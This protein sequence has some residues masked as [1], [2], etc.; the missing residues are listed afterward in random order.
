[1]LNSL[2]ISFKDTLIY[3]LGNIAVKIV[4]LV[5]IPLYTNPH[6]FSIDDFGIIGILEISGLVLTA[7]MASALPQSLTRWFWDTK[8]KG[9]QKGIFFM[10]FA[11]QLVV[12][13]LFCIVL[14]PLSGEFS[15]LIFSKSDLSGVLK[16]VILASSIQ[17]INNI[18]NTLM[19]LQSRSSLYTVT[20]LFKLILVLSLTI[21][22]I[23]VK[24]LGIEGIYLSQVIGNAVSILVLTKYIIRN[25]RIYF[26]TGIFRSMNSYGFPLF[27]ANISS[28]LLNVIDRY[29]LNSLAY[30]KSVALYTLAFKITSVLKLAI[31][32]SMKLALGPMMLKKI[33]SP[34]IK[35]FY[36]KVLVYSSYVLMFAIVG[37][38]LLSFE[39]IKVM[40]NSKQF[41]DAVVII[42]ILSLSIYFVNLKDVTIYGLH[43]VKKTRVIGV[44]VVF[45]SVLSLCLNL[46]LIPVWDIT[47]SAVATLISQLAYFYACY[48]FSQRVFYVPYELK[49]IF[50]LLFVGGIISFSGLL[51]NHMDLL[52]RL[53]LKAGL[54]LSFPFILVLFRFYEPEE[55]SAI[56]GFFRKWS[57]LS[58]L[59]ENIRSLKNIPDELQE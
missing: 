55:L 20:N 52:P 56:R 28:V 39:L 26:D 47:G 8:F 53:F 22:F 16:L 25:S 7:S 31:A 58:M 10:T 6:F 48:Y 9:N 37:V 17:S 34:D 57:R 12:S 42:P 1:M 13:A 40:A 41:W 36:S 27:L 19:R 33:G 44:I 24:K 54:I 11:T 29:S 23:T 50:I 14:I 35:R 3:G 18:A 38:S 49:K 4:G 46:L 45:S 32:D 59:G 2:K 5:L 15:G 21:Y 43:V 30:L 51:I